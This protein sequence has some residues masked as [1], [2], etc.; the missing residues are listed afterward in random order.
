VA[1]WAAPIMVPM[2]TSSVARVK[3]SDFLCLIIFPLQFRF[4]SARNAAAYKNG[5]T[6]AILEDLTGIELDNLRWFISL[7]S[8]AW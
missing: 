8:M 7:S 5:R 2:A 3:T 1:L 4:L 6:P